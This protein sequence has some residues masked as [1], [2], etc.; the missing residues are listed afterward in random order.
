MD[1]F[2]RK[3]LTEAGLRIQYEGFTV[4]EEKDG[5]LPI[6]RAGSRVCNVNGNGGIAYDPE[7]IRRK[8]LEDALDRVREVAGDTLAYMRRMETA[9]PLLAEGLSGD[10]RLLAEFNHIVLAG[11]EREGNYGVE[12]VTWERIR[13]GTSLWQGQLRQQ[14]CCR[15]AGFCH[16]LRTDPLQPPFHTGAACG[17]LRRSAEHD[18]SGP[19]FQSGAGKTSGRDHETNRRSGAA[20]DRSGK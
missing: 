15:K 7:Q 20:G 14:L 6:E 11:H 3:Y 16:P 13:N 12:F 19:R 10:Y 8:G 18:Y 4:C 2:E 17:N 9:P 1:D 5:L